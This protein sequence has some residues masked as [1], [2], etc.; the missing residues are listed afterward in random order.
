[1]RPPRLLPELDHPEAALRMTDGESTRSEG[2]Q[3][4]ELN[5]YWRTSPLPPT[6]YQMLLVLLFET[7]GLPSGTGTGD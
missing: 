1:M 4:V 3:A 2:S 5:V 6:R 7:G